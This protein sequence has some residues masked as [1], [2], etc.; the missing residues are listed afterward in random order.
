MPSPPHPGGVSVPL[1]DSFRTISRSALEMGAIT[2][3][4]VRLGRSLLLG[5]DAPASLLYLGVVYV[6]GAVFIMGMAA[7]HLSNYTV[8]PWVWRA[9]A[10]ALAEVAAE[11]LTSRVLIA[12][13][14]EQVGTWSAT[15]SDWSTLA[16][17][18]LYWRAA[19][20]LPFALV[21]ATIVQV[22]RLW[23]ARGRNDEPESLDEPRPV[24][25]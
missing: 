24:R 25:G 14:R 21:L 7:L 19:L 9:P 17:T 5:G 18:I 3:V 2:G 12:F 15:L 20:L 16:G 13:G 11:V 23:M 10:F 8:R 4:V 22:V 1:P 6:L